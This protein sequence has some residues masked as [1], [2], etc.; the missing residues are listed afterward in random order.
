MYIYSTQTTDRLISFK[1]VSFYYNVPRDY[2]HFI[3]TFLETTF[4]ISNENFK[5]EIYISTC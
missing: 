5:I 3:I 1:L 2:S 4:Q